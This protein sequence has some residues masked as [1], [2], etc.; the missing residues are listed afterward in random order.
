MFYNFFFFFLG[1]K[2]VNADTKVVVQMKHFEQA[3]SE[4]T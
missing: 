1:D 3:V 2:K 4:T